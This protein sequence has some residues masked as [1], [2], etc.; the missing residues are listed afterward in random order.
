MKYLHSMPTHPISCP[1]DRYHRDGRPYHV[2][3]VIADR[4]M[5]VENPA[6]IADGAGI[7]ET[8]IDPGQLN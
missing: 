2:G 3:E 6:P 7:V 4:P 5:D 8:R 1:F